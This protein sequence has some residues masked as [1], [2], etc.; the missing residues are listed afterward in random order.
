MRRRLNKKIHISWF[1]AWASFGFLVGVVLSIFSWSKA[2]TDSTWLVTSASL[3]LFCVIKQ[4]G[5]FIIAALT[6]GLFL[7]LWRGAIEQKALLSYQPL[8]GKIITLSGKVTEDTSYG[9]QGDQR[10]RLGYVKINN[11]PL[12]EEIWVSTNSIANIKRGDILKISGVLEKGFGNI[13]VSMYR[14]KI[15]EDTRPYPG[16]IG[17]R[18]RDKFAEGAKKAIPEPEVSLGLGYLVGQ[19]STLPDSLDQEIKTVGLTHAVVASGYNLTILVAFAA[20]VFAKKSK[21]LAVFTSS[22]MISSFMLITGFS[23]SM[24]R[25]GLVSGLGL[26]AWYYGRKIHP[27]VL[28]PFAAA[29]TALIRPAYVWGDIGWYLSFT[30]FVGVIVLAPLIH[31]YFWGNNK[32][33]HKIRLLFI[34]TSSAQLA[35]GAI[36]LLAFH[37][38]SPY[39]LFANLLVLPFVPLAMMFT[40]IAGLA[41]LLVPSIAPLVGLPAA[42]ILRYSIRVINYIA[43]LPNAKME[44]TFSVIGLI[45]SYMCLIA[46]AVYLWKKT[47]H[48]FRDEPVIS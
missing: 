28:L 6:A 29:I 18:I 15:I 34:E 17:I 26:L 23:P 33:P 14:A 3:F 9:P 1:I 10:M 5:F 19:R 31:H 48:K 44:V 22:V 24:S 36:I 21:F 38:Y 7:G 43:N 45:A 25:A 20:G 8:Y 32:K 47:K 4:K 46:G 30:A 13:P 2:F 35:T 37:Q 41:G 42:I 27:L 40:F 39:A 12:P 16:D 11:Q